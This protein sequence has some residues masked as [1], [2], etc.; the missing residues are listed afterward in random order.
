[1]VLHNDVAREFI[2]VAFEYLGQNETGQA[3]G[4]KLFVSGKGNMI[5]SVKDVSLSQISKLIR[6]RVANSALG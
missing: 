2:V 3:G 5:A 1:M 4:L 6:G